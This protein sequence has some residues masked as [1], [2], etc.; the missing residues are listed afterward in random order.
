[1]VQVRLESEFFLRE[2]LLFPQDPDAI[3]NQ[4]FDVGHGFPFLR[5]L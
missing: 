5:V 4:L 2:A 1:M 3:S